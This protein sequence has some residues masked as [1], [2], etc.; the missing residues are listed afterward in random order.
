MIPCTKRK[1]HSLNLFIYF[2]F[3]N[4]RQTHSLILIIFIW[5][6]IGLDLQSHIY[7]K[8]TIKSYPRKKR[9]K[10]HQNKMWFFLPG[11]MWLIYNL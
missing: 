8:K 3:E 9:E 4:K 7:K 5:Y 2:F 10:D 1:S 11:A 6:L